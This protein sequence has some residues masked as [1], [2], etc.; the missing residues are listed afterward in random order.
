VVVIEKPFGI[1]GFLVY[2]SGEKNL[3]LKSSGLE[4]KISF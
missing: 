1:L 2:R 4:Y 3:S